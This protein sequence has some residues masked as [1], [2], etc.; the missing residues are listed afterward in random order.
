MS[1]RNYPAARHESG[2]ATVNEARR[3]PLPW[4]AIV[5]PIFLSQM[6]M[7]DETGMGKFLRLALLLAL[8][9]LVMSRFSIAATSMSG[10]EKGVMLLLPLMVVTGSISALVLGYT[11]DIAEILKFV[12]LNLLCYALGKCV[13]TYREAIHLVDIFY[14]VCVFAAV[15]AI[16]AI[17]LDVLGLR[18]MY[19]IPLIDE[20]D[21]RYFLPWFGLLGGDVANFRTNFYF[22]ESTYFAQMLLPAIAYAMVT[23]RW[24]GFAI[25]LLGLATSSSASGAVALSGV[26]LLITARH[27]V[28]TWA[29]L[30]LVFTIVTAAYVL[31]D[32]LQGSTALLTLLDRGQSISDKV[33]SFQFIVSQISQHPFGAGP[34][35][36]NQQFGNLVNT[37]N[38]LLQL[39]VLYG[40]LAVPLLAALVGSL[41]YLGCIAPR[42][43]VSAA[44]AIGVLGTAASGATHGPLLKY[45]AVTLFALTVVISRI[46]A[47]SA[48]RAETRQPE[49]MRGQS[50]AGTIADA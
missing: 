29:M 28:P 11:P 12:A 42:G 2:A 47:A 15:Q 18:Q 5:A 38:G 35:N 48:A 46:E 34:V 8:L 9:A 30:L 36:A 13:V 39:F 17:G 26:L 24:W 37:G 40:V 23:R 27:R 6:P 3:Q 50:P 20:A 10:A 33:Q 49:P 14:V 22:S 41:L 43:P 4:W 7:L 19:V 32:V 21:R 45:Y 1:F 44:L 25:L 16:V 31:L